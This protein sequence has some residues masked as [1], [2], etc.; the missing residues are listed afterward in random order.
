MGTT[1]LFVELLVIGVGAVLWS[2]LWTVAFFGIPEIPF[3]VLFTVP[4]LFIGL[5]YTY[6]FGILTDRVA[7]SFFSGADN[8]IRTHYFYTRAE[9]H[10][11]R[12]FVMEGSPAV[13]AELRY[14]RSRLRICRG[15]VFNC[16]MSLFAFNSMII[17]SDIRIHYDPLLDC[18][19]GTLGFLC[20]GMVCLFSWWKLTDTESRKIRHSAKYLAEKAPKR[21]GTIHQIE[22]VV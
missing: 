11:K 22:L 16:V 1:D 2:C 5:A 10:E 18:M 20:M 7:D 9:Y 15:W 8:R 17:F 6:L 12:R 3:E 21:D 14:I 4:G 13:G 19:V